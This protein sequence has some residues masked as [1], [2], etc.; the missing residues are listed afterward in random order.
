M[1]GALDPIANP[2]SWDV[3]VIGTQ[4]S[5]GF[6]KVGEFKRA[7]E[8]DVKKGKGTLGGTVTF[9]GRPPARGSITFYLWTRE[10]FT[11]WDTFRD[12]LKFDPSRH[13]VQAVDMFHP[14]LADIGV[15]SVVTESIGNIVHEGS[16][17]YS[18]TVE[19]LEYFAPP[20][21]SAVGTPTGSLSAGEAT[22]KASVADAQQQEI[23]GLLKQAGAP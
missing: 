10:H 20:K 6:C 19:F 11:A 2:Q 7:F 4:T 21:A 8:W 12:L 22:S 15:N 17:L 9:V 3:V 5:P 23:D 13:A 16:Q 14:S 1:S 18:I